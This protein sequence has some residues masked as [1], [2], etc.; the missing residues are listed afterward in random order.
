VSGLFILDTFAG[1]RQ[2]FP[3]PL[4][5]F[6]TPG[7]GEV[8]VKGLDMFVRGF[9]FR[10]GVVHRERL[11]ADVRR[12]YL[13]PHP[14]WSSRT[15]EL[16]FPREIPASA[17]GPVAELIT[18]VERGLEQHFRSKPARIMWAMRDPAFTP[19][20][21]ERWRK[22]LP[23]APVTQLDDASH[24]LQ[25]DAHERIVPQLL[26]FLAGTSP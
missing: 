6:R 5:L 11:T 2:D 4:R 24:Y 25:E 19:M 1:W 26:G 8:L 3:V 17:T 9:V 10:A 13:A 16:V 21:L 12:A 20:V 7:V 14:T 22:T 15:G 23:D 18:R